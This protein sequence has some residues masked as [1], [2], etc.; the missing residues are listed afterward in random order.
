DESRSHGAATD[1]AGIDES[2]NR[3][4]AGSVGGRG[5]GIAPAGIPETGGT[6]AVAIGE[7]GAG[8][9]SRSVIVRKATHAPPAVAYDEPHDA[10]A[11]TG[12]TCAR[13]GRAAELE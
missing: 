11:K 12:N 7:G 5:K 10:F 1:P 13:F 4:A 6:H 2:R 3:R 8:A 9:I